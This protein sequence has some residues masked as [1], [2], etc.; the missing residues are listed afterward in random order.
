MLRGTVPLL[1]SDYLSQKLAPHQMTLLDLVLRREAPS[2]PQ[3]TEE[4]EIL[5]DALELTGVWGK[6][7]DGYAFVRAFLMDEERIFVQT[8]IYDF[9][10]SIVPEDVRSR[11]FTWARSIDELLIKVMAQAHSMT[12]APGTEPEIVPEDHPEMDAVGWR[13]V[14]ANETWLINRTNAARGE[15]S[16]HPE[17]VQMFQTG[18]GRRALGKLLAKGGLRNVHTLTPTIQSK[19]GAVGREIAR[20]D[21]R[22]RIDL[23]SKSAATA[24]M[25]R[26]GGR[27]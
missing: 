5:L 3:L 7:D 20:A 16:A 12:G 17:A 19:N 26:K 9:A 10:D 6:R 22:I 23:A 14:Q 1:P 21:E 27:G 4:V 15:S 18:N 24:F 13:N 2:T 8:R 25:Q 11:K